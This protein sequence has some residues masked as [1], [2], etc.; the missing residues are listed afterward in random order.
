[1]ERPLA[2]FLA[3]ACGTGACEAPWSPSGVGPD[4]GRSAELLT[5]DEVPAITLDNDVVPLVEKA[6][7]GSADA[8]GP[9]VL[10]VAYA[11]GGPKPDVSRTLN[12]ICTGTAPA[13]ECTW[14]PGGVDACKRRIQ[15]RLDVAYQ[16]FDLV[17]TFQRP[18]SGLF[19]T[20]LVTS[21]G[22]WCKEAPANFG[23]ITRSGCD[24]VSGGISYAL[25]CGANFADPAGAC[26]FIIAHEHGHLIGL[27]HTAG[28]ADIMRT[29]V[30]DTCGVFAKEDNKVRG[31][32]CRTTQN[33]YGMMLDRIGAWTGGA[34]PD[35]F[36]APP[37]P[38]PPTPAPCTDSAPPTV[39]IS[40]PADG[41]TV[42]QSFT[43]T[44]EASDDC[45]GVAKSHITVGALSAD[46]AGPGPWEWVLND[47]T[48]PLVITV[49]ATD[50]QGNVG[51]ASITV[52]GPA[53]VPFSD[54]GL[55]DDAEAS[56]DAVMP[57][58]GLVEPPTKTRGCECGVG[59]RGAG[60]GIPA[61]LAVGAFVIVR[62]RHCPGRRRRGQKCI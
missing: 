54:A 12:Y 20:S 11:D 23:G 13:F 57:D 29:S 40:A 15:A 49:E 33:S 38:P 42:G 28:T 30:C 21:N 6:G 17:F 7:P 36:A 27:M 4:E 35:P 39:T 37:P 56:D 41:A 1:M 51:S 55:P 16:D 62:R 48:G 61:L 9:R 43:V 18:T 59:A 45:S 10:Y 32:D 14:D 46:S 52:T 31:P 24:V 2:F 58:V 47:L 8:S 60:S 25:R 34:K 50:A 3:L 5:L 53:P 22:D 26:A 19:D 44:A